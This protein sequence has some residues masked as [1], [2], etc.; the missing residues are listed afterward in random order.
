MAGIKLNLVGAIR[1]KDKYREF[2]NIKGKASNGTVFSWQNPVLITVNAAL[3]QTTDLSVNEG[4]PTLRV[5][6]GDG[7]VQNVNSDSYPIRHTY[8]SSSGTYQIQITGVTI[9]KFNLVLNS[10]V[11]P[12][13][14]ISIDNYFSGGNNLLP[15]SLS[16]ALTSLPSYLPVTVS[17]IGQ[18]MNNSTANV[19][20][21]Q[22][23]DTG[24]VTN[25]QRAFELTGGFNQNISS[26]N[27][28]AVTN[29]SYM[30]YFASSF[31]QNISSWDTSAV[32]SMANMFFS[33]GSF[34]QDLSYW[35]IPN[36]T[37]MQGMFRDSGMSTEN[38]SRT[39]I[40]WA[41]NHFSGNAKNNVSLGATGIS[42]NNTNYTTGNQFNN[43]VSA[44]FYLV[45]TAGWTIL[46]AG[47]V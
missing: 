38:Y 27:T 18:C 13:N 1:I 33:A 34:N 24:G 20:G 16:T 23:W 37:D 32:T 22:N 14:L 30:F 12:S 28:S 5:D 39:L 11:S 41:N 7:V 36:V 3:N 43:A 44:R 31:N 35:D 9:G 2:G 8:P 42:Y 10:S 25:F 4:E 47:A 45:N 46:D 19:S 21:P 26:W 15:R 6:W 29:M 17:S 40:G